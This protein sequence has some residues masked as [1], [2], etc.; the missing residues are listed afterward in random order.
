MNVML[1]V[2]GTDLK[3]LSTENTD[4]YP[5]M[6][7]VSSAQ[8]QALQQSSEQQWDLEQQSSG[9][10][11]TTIVAVAVAVVVTVFLAAVVLRTRKKGN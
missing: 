11:F 3:L 9:S 10:N 8:A 2:E 6:S 7:P 5:L 4:H 1:S